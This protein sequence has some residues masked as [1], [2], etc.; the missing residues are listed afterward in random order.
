[1]GGLRR[2]HEEPEAAR[3]SEEGIAFLDAEGT[4]LDGLLPRPAPVMVSHDLAVVVELCSHLIV[5]ARGQMVEAG[6]TG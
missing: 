4:G 5:M 6:A 2:H 3:V 1:M